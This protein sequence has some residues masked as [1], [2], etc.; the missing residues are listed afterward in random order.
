MPGAVYSVIDA[1]VLSHF[2]SVILRSHCALCLVLNK[3]TCEN[4]L[5]P[6]FHVKH[7]HCFYVPPTALSH[8]SFVNF[9]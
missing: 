8:V 3:A 1:S 5:L 6:Y 9:E 7:K 4:L 2:G